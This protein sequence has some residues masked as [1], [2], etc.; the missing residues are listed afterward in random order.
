[1]AIDQTL[2]R[3]AIAREIIGSVDAMMAALYSAR[4]KV[5]EAASG[6]LTFADGDFSSSADMTHVTAANL[7][8]ANSNVLTLV[9]T[10]EAGFIDD[11]FNV[12]RP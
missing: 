5:N 9:T 4:D 2:K 8:T 6:G 7:T 1:M 3:Q 12:I 10:L 11:V